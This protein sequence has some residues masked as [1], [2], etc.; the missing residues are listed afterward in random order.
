MLA[1]DRLVVDRLV[2]DVLAQWQ[3]VCS[4]GAFAV[5]GRSWRFELRPTAHLSLS[6]VVVP[7]WAVRAQYKSQKEAAELATSRIFF[8]RPDAS[9]AAVFTKGEIYLIHWII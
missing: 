1:V 3:E 5:L 2:V 9:C 4:D 6:G 8:A 7:E